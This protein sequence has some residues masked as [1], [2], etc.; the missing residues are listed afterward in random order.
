MANSADP[1]QLAS[2]LDLHCLQRKG[3]SRFSR[4]RVKGTKFAEKGE[5]PNKQHGYAD[6]CLHAEHNKFSHG[7]LKYYFVIKQSHP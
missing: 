7:K 3:I 1:D 2:D 6:W 4:A 5:N